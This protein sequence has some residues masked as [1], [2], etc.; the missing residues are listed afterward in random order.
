M[1]SGGRTIQLPTQANFI[2]QPIHYT[3]LDSDC[4]RICAQIGD[5]QFQHERE[6]HPAVGFKQ[7]IDT[8]RW[9]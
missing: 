5:R 2:Q 3:S 6:T 1:H 9:R 7:G 8:N 4:V